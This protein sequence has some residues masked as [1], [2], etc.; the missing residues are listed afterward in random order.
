MEKQLK[1]VSDVSKIEV[2]ACCKP[3]KGEEVK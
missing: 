3:S 2:K 1:D